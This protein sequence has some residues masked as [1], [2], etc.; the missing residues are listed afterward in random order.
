M[1][2]LPK[3]SDIT[4]RKGITWA[5]IEEMSA[6]GN[7]KKI[8]PIETIY[9]GYRF[10]SRLE[11]RWAVFFDAL[12]VDYE[13]E[14]EGF[15]LP[16]GGRY[17]PDFRVKCYGKRGVC[18]E[19]KTMEDTRTCGLCYSCKYRGEDDM[20][21]YQY[22]CTND[23]LKRDEYGSVNCAKVDEDL[24]GMCVKCDGFR[25]DVGDPFNLYIEVKG[26]MTDYDAARIR[27]FAETNPVLVVGNIPRDFRSIEWGDGM[28]GTNVYPFNYDTIDGDYFGAYPAAHNGHFYLMG[29]DSNY[30]N[31]RDID[32]IDK[33]FAKARQ[34][35]FE[36]GETPKI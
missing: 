21:S 19:P 24:N 8:K 2:T 10:R 29:A 7:D 18:R 35:R 30:I 36:H 25:L 3:L 1:I 34:A 31:K 13:Y 9:N 4:K 5:D 16:N 11:A 6:P 20:Y 26:F 27:D 28:N 14:P 23:A 12:G 33:A 32:G 17:L 22:D 15:N